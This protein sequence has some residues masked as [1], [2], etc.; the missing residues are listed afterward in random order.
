MMKLNLTKRV[1][2]SFIS[3]IVLVGL[4][5]IIVYPISIRGTLTEETYRII[6]EEQARSANPFSEYFTPPEEDF[7]FIERQEAERSVGHLFLLN[8]TGTLQGGQVPDSVLQEMIANAVDQENDQE[9]FEMLYNDATLFYV[10]NRIESD[11]EEAYQISYM[12]D[13]Y[14][15][16][17]VSRLW[18]RL[19]YLL[20]ITSALSFLPAIW[21]KRY[22]SQPLRVLGN[23]FE[24]IAKRNWKEPFHL[25]GDDDFIRLSN[26]FEGMRQN[27]IRYDRSQKTFIQHAS[28]ELKTPIMVIKTY[29]QSVKDGILPKEDIEKTMDVILEEANRMDKRVKDMLYF[30]KLDSMKRNTINLE[31]MMFGSVAFRI[32]ER[33]RM[34]RGHVKF[35]IE[36]ADVEMTADKEQVQILLENLIENAMRYAEDKI[37]IKAEET[38]DTIIISVRNNGTLIPEEELEQIFTPFQ[39]GNKGQFGLGL[40]IVQRIAELHE[41]THEAINET[42]GVCFKITIPKSLRRTIEEQ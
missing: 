18:E 1:Y 3:L 26:Q 14:R 22:L 27:L 34:K 16:L 25:E 36:G 30:T 42:D 38:A 37:W 24:Q 17:M 31:E 29:A 35:I 41:G 28:H 39:K 6:E 11:G 23:Q 33:F 20:L 21:L 13:T 15:D 9:R 5:M 19:A 40:A 2:L 10:I 12:W 32:E 8:E 7:D 4:T